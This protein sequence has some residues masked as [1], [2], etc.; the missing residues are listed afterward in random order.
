MAASTRG[1]VHALCE[2]LSVDPERILSGN[3]GEHDYKSLYFNILQLSEQKGSL[4]SNAEVLK[5]VSFVN[6]FPGDDHLARLK[7]LNDDLAQRSVLLGN[8]LSPSVADIIVFA[9]VHPY[10]S[11]L[12][13]PEMQKLPNLM[14]WMDYIQNIKDFG[15]A[16]KMISVEKTEFKHNFSEKAAKSE[17]KLEP[18]KDTKDSKNKGTL[19]TDSNTKKKD[20]EVAQVSGKTGEQNKKVSEPVE[21]KKKTEKK[22]TSENEAVEKKKTEKETAGKDTEVSVTA[23]NL[24]IGQI[25]KAWK[26]PSADSL[27]VEEINLGNGNVRQVVSGL[28][29]Y[30]S[31]D[32]LTNRLVV[33]ITNVKPGK[34]RD[35]MSA[36]L[37]LCASS[38][39][40]TTVEPLC[41]PEGAIIGECISFAGYEGKPEDVLNPKKKQL[42]KITP[43]LYTDDKGVATYKGIPF[44]TS[45]GPC[46]SSIPNAGIK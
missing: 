41:P 20:A 11:R 16:F 7:V 43:Y 44:M 27:L 28:A 26:H 1:L 35:V 31:P 4:E 39:D 25:E 42:E 46:T 2:H 12:S 45:A 22:K 10:V 34:L 36:G 32:E 13:N 19:E 17:A 3:V 21:K 5:W 40:H 23:L 29:K 6:N 14:R 38:E 24:Q 8:G 18:K 37:V 15:G 30:C 33:L 9:A